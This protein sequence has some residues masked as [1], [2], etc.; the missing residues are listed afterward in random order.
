MEANNTPSNAVT[1]E[2]RLTDLPPGAYA[3]MFLCGPSNGNG[4]PDKAYCRF[5]DRA[6]AEQVVAEF[7]EAKAKRPGDFPS[8]MEAEIVE[9]AR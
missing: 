2:I 5:D 4:N 1:Y 6:D 3:Q 7:Y 9:V 8:F